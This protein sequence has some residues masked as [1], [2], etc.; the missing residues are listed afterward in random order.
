MTQESEGQVIYD[1]AKA[2]TRLYT[3]MATHKHTLGNMLER[4]VDFLGHE[5]PA[6]KKT[7]E[8]HLQNKIKHKFVDK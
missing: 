1:K 7:E 5:I 8:S 4:Q 2:C 6:K 3:Q